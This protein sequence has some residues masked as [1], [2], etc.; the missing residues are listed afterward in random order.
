MDENVIQKNGGTKD[1][2]WC[3]CKK[4]HVCEK[5]YVWNPASCICENGKYL[6]SVSAIQRL[7]VMNL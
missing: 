1:K 7:S 2:C 6:A 3:K 4:I 5:D